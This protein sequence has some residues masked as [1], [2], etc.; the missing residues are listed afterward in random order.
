MVDGLTLSIDRLG[1]MVDGL[2]LIEDG[3][4]LNNDWLDL[5]NDSI[6]W[7]QIPWL[8]D[9]LVVLS[10]RTVNHMGIFCH[11][12]NHQHIKESLACTEKNFQSLIPATCNPPSIIQ[13]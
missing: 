13:V 4:G 2:S 11:D 9:D 8:V 7:M 5:H 12:L 6:S 3:L 10:V 1:L